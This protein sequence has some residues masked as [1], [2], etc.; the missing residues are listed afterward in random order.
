MYIH[1][2]LYVCV[3]CIPHKCLQPDLYIS[4]H[5]YMYIQTD[6]TCILYVDRCEWAYICVCT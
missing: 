3:A 2:C 1:A 6:I 4:R 5:V